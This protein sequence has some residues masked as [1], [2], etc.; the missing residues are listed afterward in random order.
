MRNVKVVTMNYTAIQLSGDKHIPSPLWW[1]SQLSQD[2][3]AS[4]LQSVWH[5]FDHT[6]HTANLLP[7]VGHSHPSQSRTAIIKTDKHLINNHLLL[8]KRWKRK[9]FYVMLY[10]LYWLSDKIQIFQV[11]SM[12][13]TF[14]ALMTVSMCVL[15]ASWE[16]SELARV[17][18]LSRARYRRFVSLCCRNWPSWLQALTKRFGSL[19]EKKW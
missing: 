15:T 12:I 2:S 14:S 7:S 16:N 13:Q 1:S 8:L 3:W 19:Q 5:C 4:Q 11:K 17:H 9:L 18:M 6:L 10:R